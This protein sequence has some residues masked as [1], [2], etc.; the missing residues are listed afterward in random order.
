MFCPERRP[1]D[2]HGL[3]GSLS[4]M[5][6]CA[7]A[8]AALLDARVVAALTQYA[9]HVQYIHV[10]DRYC[11]PKQMESVYNIDDANTLAVNVQL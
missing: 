7:E 11:G 9:A 3:P 4:V 8:T 1:G 10:S 2:K 6:E 5:S